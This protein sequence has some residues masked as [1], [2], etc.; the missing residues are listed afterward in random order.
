[1]RSIQSGIRQL[2]VLVFV[3]A[4]FSGCG[5]DDSDSPSGP[6][7]GT[8]VQDSVAVP[9]FALKDLNTNS[10]LYFEDV[11]PRDYLNRISAWYFGAAT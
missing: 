10:P 5:D 8:V 7:N 6:G 1:M 4:L 11:S 9:D 2:I 3:A